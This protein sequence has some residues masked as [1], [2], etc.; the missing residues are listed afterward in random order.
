MVRCEKF[1][2]T[3][4][5]CELLSDVFVKVL[6]LCNVHAAQVGSAAASKAGKTSETAAVRSMNNCNLPF[7]QGVDLVVIYIMVA[8]DLVRDLAYLYTLHANDEVSWILGALYL[9]GLCAR[10]SQSMP[11]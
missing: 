3:S 1:G 8:A 5:A 9:S 4:A 10:D 7:E 6:A 2:I 11:L